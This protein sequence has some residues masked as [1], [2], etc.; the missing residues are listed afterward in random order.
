MITSRPLRPGR[1][2][3]A[4]RWPARPP[5]SAAATVSPPQRAKPAQAPSAPSKALQAFENPAPER[6][7]VIRFDV[8][9]FTCLCPLTGQPDFAHFT[10]EIVADRYCVETKSLKQ[11][12]WSF[13]NEGAFHEKVTNTIVSD[14]VAAIAPRF[15]RL[16]ADW[17]VRGGIRTFVTVEERK[18]GWKPADPVALPQG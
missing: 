3:P 11:Y 18:K 4:S 1:R 2:H 14:I 12:F 6:D 17:F 7:Y 5:N 9:E 10:I 13:R 8:P 16:H 15:I